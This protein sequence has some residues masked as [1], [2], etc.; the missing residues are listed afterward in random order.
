M[1]KVLLGALHG[2]RIE[3]E[4]RVSESVLARLHF[5]L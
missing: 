2:Q 4:A 5:E 3:H 1:Q